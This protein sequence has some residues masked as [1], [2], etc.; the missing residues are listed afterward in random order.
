MATLE[1]DVLTLFPK[2]F[3]G[4]LSESLLGRAQDKGLVRIEVH[5][6]RNFT[7]DKHRKVD[8]KPFGGESG[9][10]LQVEPIFK[11]LKALSKNF[12]ARPYV[13]YLSPQGKTLDNAAAL[14]L[15]EKKRMVLIAGHYEGID[16]RAMKWVDREVSIGDY[17]LTGGELPAMVLIDAVCRMVPGVVKEKASVENDSFFKSP[18]LDHSHYT[19]PSDFL[20]MKVP[21]ILVSGNHKAVAEWRLKSSL[22]N[23]VNK[24][25][26]LLS[27]EAR[28]TLK[29][30]LQG[31]QSRSKIGTTKGDGVPLVEKPERRNTL[32]SEGFSPSSAKRNEG[33]DKGRF[34]P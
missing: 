11:A 7:K 9:M 19:R 3:S 25:P 32:R 22:Q 10:L 23:T 27:P 8:D 16:E 17:V 24:R 29:N 34:L 28:K 33:F 20:G 26:D 21:E 12:K 5:D 30:S 1:I 15:S 2:M 14:E 6:L 13:I 4:P 31:V 18:F